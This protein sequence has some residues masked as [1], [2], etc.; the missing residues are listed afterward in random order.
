MENKTNNVVI[1]I[2]V[3][4]LLAVMF[5]VGWFLG[6]KFNALERKASNDVRNSANDIIDMA[7]DTID[8]AANN[9]VI[10]S[11]KNEIDDVIVKILSIDGIEVGTNQPNHQIRVTGKI[12]VS[13]D[14][15]KYWPLTMSGYCL[16]DKGV[17]YNMYGPGSGAISFYNYDKKLKFVNTI[18]NKDGDIILADGTVK[19]IGDV[20]WDNLKI[21]SCVIEYASIFTKASNSTESKKIML[22]YRKDF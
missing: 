20:D 1:I 19:E 15:D 6:G 22:N 11:D 10:N 7:K 4:I 5:V 8:E 9:D 3:V 16:D 14:E 13:F 17:R 2:A 12:E 18:N 21:K